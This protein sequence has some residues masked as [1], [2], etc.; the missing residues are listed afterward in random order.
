MVTSE[1][2]GCHGYN[3]VGLGKKTTYPAIRTQVAKEDSKNG[4]VLIGG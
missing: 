3:A 1:F 2:Y 4:P